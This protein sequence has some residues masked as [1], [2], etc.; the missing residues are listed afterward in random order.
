MNEK[1]KK[2]KEE[3]GTGRRRMQSTFDLF[4]RRRGGEGGKVFDAKLLSNMTI[5]HGKE[6]RTVL[7]TQYRKT[8]WFKGEFRCNRVGAQM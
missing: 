8:F 6:G 4:P 3:M 1:E 2:K 7:C 5:L